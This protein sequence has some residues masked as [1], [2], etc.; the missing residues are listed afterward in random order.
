MKTC[1]VCT[2]SKQKCEF[3]K[4]KRN[5]DGLSYQCRC[6]TLKRQAL[7]RER[8]RDAVLERKRK[9]YREN[10]DRCLDVCKRY[11][12]KNKDKVAA[13]KRKW[14]QENRDAIRAN[15]S[16]EEKRME[17]RARE[18]E[19]RKNNP[20]IIRRI[21]ARASDKMTEQQRMLKTCR[22]RLRHALDGKAKVASTKELIGC[23]PD[24][25]VSYLEGMFADGMTWDNYGRHGWHVDHIK[26]CVSFDLSDP[27]QQRECFHYTNLQPLW[28]NDNL[29]KGCKTQ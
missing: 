13:Y 26:P 11:V 14:Y 6:C 2:Q 10:R 21:K 29:S 23:T 7:Y 9:Y 28:A 15:N 18:R 8:N 24:E 16:S 25:L 20:D 1:S 3:Y 27:E 17:I 4:V 22:T 5:P 12:E 19:Y